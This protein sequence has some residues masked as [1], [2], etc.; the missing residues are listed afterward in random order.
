MSEMTWTSRVVC[1]H[2]AVLARAA[3]IDTWRAHDDATC[4]VP[5]RVDAWEVGIRAGSAADRSH[6]RDAVASISGEGVPL[7]GAIARLTRLG[8][9]ACSVLLADGELAAGLA[10]GEPLGLGE[11]GAWEFTLTSDPL[12]EH[13]STPLTPGTIV[14]L[15]SCGPT[16]FRLPYPQDPQVTP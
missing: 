16:V 7:P 2:S 11:I 10:W 3:T 6:V 12:P 13:P 8:M 14:V 9:P 1:E 4:S 15:D 5:G